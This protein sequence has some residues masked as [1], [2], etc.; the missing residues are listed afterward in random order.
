MVSLSFHT[1]SSLPLD[2]V[3]LL[4]SLYNAMWNGLFTLAALFVS[5][6]FLQQNG[7]KGQYLL[8]LG[9]SHDHLTDE[10]RLTFHRRWRRDWACR[11]DEPHGMYR[12]LSP[13]F[14]PNPS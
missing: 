1:A 14:S 2:F 11:R 7:V 6:S 3:D 9:E 10:S 4:Q 5:T 13:P 8:G 12:P